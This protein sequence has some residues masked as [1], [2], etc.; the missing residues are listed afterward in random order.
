MP[1][2]LGASEARIVG[3]HSPLAWASFGCGNEVGGGEISHRVVQYEAGQH[4]SAQQ[5]VNKYSVLVLLRVSEQHHHHDLV[6]EQVVDRLS[7]EN[8]SLE[9]ERMAAAGAWKATQTRVGQQVHRQLVG[10]Q[11]RHVGYEMRE[12]LFIR[13]SGTILLSLNTI[14]YR[15]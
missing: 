8:G 6:D 10:E 3:E 9:T 14:T 5:L 2:L 7:E 15:K 1:P 4:R 11:D 13:R 12:S